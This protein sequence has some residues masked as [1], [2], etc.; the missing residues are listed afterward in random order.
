MRKMKVRMTVT[1]TTMMKKRKMVRRRRRRTWGKVCKYG[2]MCP[3]G[4]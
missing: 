2:E 3:S 4:E 1:K